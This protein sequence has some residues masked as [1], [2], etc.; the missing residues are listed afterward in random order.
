MFAVMKHLVHALSFQRDAVFFGKPSAGPLDLVRRR[1][2]EE[3]GEELRRVAVE[4]VVE[5]V[6]KY[7]EVPLSFPTHWHVWVEDGQVHLTKLYLTN[8][9]GGT[10]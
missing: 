5:G 4:S 7:I 2:A 8:A 9:P 10:A 6:M 3:V 1:T